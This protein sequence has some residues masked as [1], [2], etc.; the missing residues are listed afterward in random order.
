MNSSPSLLVNYY[1][2]SSVV[3]VASAVTRRLDATDITI[4]AKPL[5]DLDHQHRP[6][7]SRRTTL[8]DRYYLPI[9]Y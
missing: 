2:Y 4:A 8:R 3:A 1:Y 7:L 9:R 6:D 5:V